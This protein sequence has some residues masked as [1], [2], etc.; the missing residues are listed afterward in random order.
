MNI[1]RKIL[2]STLLM[3]AISVHG[4]VEY[5]IQNGTLLG[6]SGIE[7]NGDIYS[8]TFEDSCFS[9][10]SGCNETL[11]DFTTQS[12]AV[13]ALDALFTQVFV[14]DVIIDGLEY[15]FV[16]SPELT[17]SCDRVG[18]CE[19]WVPYD[20]VGPNQAISAWWVNVPGGYYVGQ[21]D[22]QVDINYGDTEEYMAFTNFE[23]TSEVPI[24]AAAWLF[25]S[26]LAGL[27]VVRRKK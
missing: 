14:N 25:G 6:A 11:F 1:L 20:T 26:A 16:D 3:S 24:P 23:L 27:G 4:A 18:F 17:Q 13:D 15:D 7:I 9:A 5:N 21:N 2:I 12:E 8:V 22:Y 10:Y 19:I